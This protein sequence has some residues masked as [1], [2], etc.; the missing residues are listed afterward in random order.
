MQ[1]WAEKEKEYVAQGFTSEQINEYK[2]RKYN[3]Y[4]EGGVDPTAVNSYFGIKDPDEKILADKFKSHLEGYQPQEADTILEAIDAGWQVSSTALLSKAYKGQN[5]NPDT[6][7]PDHAPTYMKVAQGLA[8]VTGDVP[9]MVAGYIGGKSAGALV[10]GAIGSKIPAVGTVAGATIGGEFGAQ[11]GANMAPEFVRTALIEYYNRGEMKTAAEFTDFASTVF[12]KTAKAGAVGALTY[13]AGKAVAGKFAAAGVA[14]GVTSVARTSS[15]IVTMTTVGKALEGELPNMEDFT[16]SA[17]IIGTIG[18][19]GAGVNYSPKV[20]SKLQKIYAKTGKMPS[21]IVAEVNADPVLKQQILSENDAVPQ[22]GIEQSKIEVPAEVKP[23]VVETPA[24]V[25]S[26]N[27]ARIAEQPDVPKTTMTADGLYTYIVDKLY[28]IKSNL[29]KLGPESSADDVYALFRM[30]PDSKAKV[31][32][33]IEKGSLSFTDLSYNGKSFMDIIKP[34]D[35]ELGAVDGFKDYLISKRVMELE[36]KGIKH[37]FDTEYSKK[38]VKANEAKYESSAKE[39]YDYNNRMIDYLVDAEVLTRDAA[40]T[41]KDANKSYISFAR[42]MEDAPRSK[43]KGGKL[44]K[45]IK[46]SEKLIQD[47][48]LSMIEN[49][50]MYMQA[51]EKNRA[52]LALVKAVESFREDAGDLLTKEPSPIKGIEVKTEEV[53]K[54]LKDQG[55]DADAEAFTIFRSADKRLGKNQIEVYREGKREVWTVNDDLLAESLKSIEFSSKTMNP[56]LQMMGAVTKIK[57]IG[58]SITPEFISRNFFRDQITSGIFTQSDAISLADTVTAMGDILKKND[59]YYRWLKSGGANGAFM[60]MGERYLRNDIYKSTEMLTMRDKA[61]NVVT[62][63]VQWLELAGNLAESSTRLAEFKRV[64]K[65]AESGAILF[66]GGM[67][68]REITLD[69]QRVGLKTQALNQIVA[70]LNPT[71]QGLDKTARAIKADPKKFT[72]RAAAMVTLPSVLLW[73]ANR[74]DERYKE[75]PQWQKDFFWV[76]P[77]DDWQE[78]KPEDNPYLLPKYL[79]KTENGK[80]YVNKGIIYRV[81]KPAEIGLIFGSIPERVLSAFY[82]DNKSATFQLKDT[83]VSAALPNIMPDAIAPVL[84]QMTNKSFFSGSPLIPFNLEKPLSE[85]QYREYT[86]DTAILLGKMIGYVPFIRDI[87]SDNIKLS[88]PIV[89]ENYIRNWTGTVGSYALQLS[90]QAL[91][92]SGF[93]KTE[94]YPS[95]TLADLPVIRAFVARHPSMSADSIQRFNEFYKKHEK[96]RATFDLLVKRQQTEQA[97]AFAEEHKAKFFKLN[98]FRDT[99]SKQND[100]IYNV[101][102]NKTYTADEKRQLIDSVY[103]QMVETAKAGLEV[104]GQLDEITEKLKSE[105]IEK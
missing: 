10:G 19:I 33:F 43:G 30:I 52:N 104:T 40:K 51:A 64:T 85:V 93:K 75:I 55:I 26:P 28:P 76:I 15:E 47:P 17:A 9:A 50:E 97:A 56:V 34:F 12:L 63:P 96:Y 103:Y 20:V 66:K 90:D 41:I 95:S 62:K 92:A 11:A 7:V 79:V 23:D 69:F 77:T 16:T 91:R 42:V 86:S 65:G 78:A 25:Q 81:P 57:K 39:F 73:F 84:E 32:A 4:I 87:G 70:Y 53:A 31:K 46:G 44:I 98:G 35:K 27:L 36:A 101:F 72:Q 82:D 61:M 24:E 94:T 80:M 1:T 99:I 38:F 83:L 88:S 6:I 37:G 3:E 102:Y 49:F 58:I 60:E 45:S 100:F 67:A 2:Q 18:T 74:D 8:T 13:G 105:G 21:D 89:V 54:F 71:I 68:S 48:F 14:Q 59:E 5:I 29:Q 22:Y